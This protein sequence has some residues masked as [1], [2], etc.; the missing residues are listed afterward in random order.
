MH[1]SQVTP[2]ALEAG[3]LSDV[4]EAIWQDESDED[5][6]PIPEADS[7]TDFFLRAKPLFIMKVRDKRKLPRVS[8]TIVKTKAYLHGLTIQ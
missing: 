5:P 8:L 4:Q 1:T 3:S 6:V 2:S 7:N